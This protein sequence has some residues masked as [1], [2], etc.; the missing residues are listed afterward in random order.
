MPA[1]LPT[2]RV[3]LNGVFADAAYEAARVIAVFCRNRQSAQLGCG[4]G[5]SL[6]DHCPFDARRASK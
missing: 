4:R 3:T 1:Q 5:Q 2:R 6:T